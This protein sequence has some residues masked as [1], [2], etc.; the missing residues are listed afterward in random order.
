MPTQV[1]QAS[2]NSYLADIHRNR[3]VLVLAHWLMALPQRAVQQAVHTLEHTLAP[4][5]SLVV[6]EALAH[7]TT[8]VQHLNN[9][10]ESKK[11][12]TL[13]SGITVANVNRF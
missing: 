8:Y 2:M 3:L 13:V 1:M 10:T 6:Q 9:Y 7:A 11:N 12:A 4:S 5:T